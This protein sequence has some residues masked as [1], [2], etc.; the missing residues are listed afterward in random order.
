MF[1]GFS[2]QAASTEQGGTA[3][4]QFMAGQAGSRM[5]QAAAACLAFL[6]IPLGGGTHTEGETPRYPYSEL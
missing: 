6:F 4:K 3:E 5:Q 2:S 1:R